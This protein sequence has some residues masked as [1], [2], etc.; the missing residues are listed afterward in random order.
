M[1]GSPAGIRTATLVELL[2][3]VAT[4]GVLAATAVPKLLGHGHDAVD[5]TTKADLRT[6][7]GQLEAYRAQAGAYPTARG[8]VSFA[9]PRLTIR[10]DT[11]VLAPGNTPRIFTAGPDRA[12][13]RVRNP[14]GT[15]AVR[16]YVWK[17][18]A[19][20]LQAAGQTCA[21]YPRAL[22]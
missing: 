15:D 20:G 2:L 9:A 11:L 1:S 14:R 13:I 5:A 17:S 18:D 4:V 21:G 19:G 22:L 8:Q 7:A 12:C 16:G 10:E 6:V 3:V